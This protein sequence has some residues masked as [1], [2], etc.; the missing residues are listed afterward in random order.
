M[1]LVGYSNALLLF[2]D[3]QIIS[4]LSHWTC[5][6]WVLY[7]LGKA[8]FIFDRLW[9]EESQCVFAPSWLQ[10]ENVCF[11]WNS[12]FLTMGIASSTTIQTLK[13]LL[14]IWSFVVVKMRHMHQFIQLEHQFIQLEP[15]QK[16]EGFLLTSLT[17]DCN[18]ILPTRRGAS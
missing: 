16:L 8:S 6:S 4:F 9:L 11:P 3:V 1:S 13:S 5:F 18:L 12:S 10:H 7:S 2:F 17:L 15:A 14:L